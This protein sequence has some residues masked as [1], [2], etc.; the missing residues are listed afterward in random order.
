M[1]KLFVYL[2]L[3]LALSLLLCGC[4]STPDSGNVAASPWPEVTEPVLPM[5]SAAVS[6]TP[7]AD[8]IQNG[9]TDSPVG[10]AMPEISSASPRP[11]DTAG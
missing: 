11:A 8:R 9:G 4:G 5:P 2:A 7:N 10:S 1:K 6:P 3:T